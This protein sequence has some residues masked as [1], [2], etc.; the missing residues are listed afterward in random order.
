MSR[1]AGFRHTEETLN[2][3]RERW[4]KRKNRNPF[5]S[6]KGKLN[7][8][9]GVSLKGKRNG[10]WKGGRRILPSGY[11]AIYKPEH[12]HRDKDSYVMEHRL[13]MEQTIGRYL[14]PTEVVHH[15]NGIHDDN[16]IE[17]LKLFTTSAEHINAHVEM[18][19]RNEKGQFLAT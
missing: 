4:K 2:K 11:I 3:L 16:R 18:R 1:P 17:N 15:I 7:P 9:A 12:P 13:V 10:N 5:G 8:M 19:R 14:K 6:H